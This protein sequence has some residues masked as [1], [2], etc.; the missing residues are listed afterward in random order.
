MP[1][2]ISNSALAK[3]IARNNHCSLAEAKKALEIVLNG[4]TD[5]LAKGN[6]VALSNFGVFTPLI[7]KHKVSKD[8]FSDQ[9]IHVP[10]H[11]NIVFDAYTYLKDRVAKKEQ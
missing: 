8:I 7:R 10:K 1:E 3:Q 6:S 2:K 9:E 4:I 11:A 5:E